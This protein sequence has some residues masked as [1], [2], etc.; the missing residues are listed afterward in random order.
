MEEN[1]TQPQGEVTEK[2]VETPSEGQGE[3]EGDGQQP[4][5][6]DLES[7]NKHFESKFQDEG[8]LREGLKRLGQYEEL[9]NQLLAKDA[10][11]EAAAKKASKYDEFLDYYK[12]EN[13]YGDDETFAFVEMKKK[14]PDRDPG[15]VSVIRSKDFDSMSDLDKLVIANKLTVKTDISDKERREGILT[16]LGVESENS[17]EWTGAEKFRL[18]TAYSQVSS[19]IDEIRNFKPEPQTFDIV[20]EKERRAEEKQKTQESL[21]KKVEPIAKSLVNNYQ[22]AKAYV[23]D[24][25]GKPVEIFNYKVDASFREQFA[26]P[27][28]DKVVEQGLDLTVPENAESVAQ[29]ID[30]QYKLQNF[31]RIVNEAMKFAKTNTED[32]AHNK[33]HSDKPQN[34]TEAPPPGKKD[35]YTIAEWIKLKAAKRSGK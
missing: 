19:A 22:E 2:P 28:I 10:E 14:F 15:L 5:S 20:A 32:E 24:K 27:L 12:P 26:Q 3:G 4:T 21:R 6:Y 16:N 9:N 1:T 29:Y 11:L 34:T 18:A 13:L 23:K 7:F 17:S 31:N 25:D 33:I 30:E 8:S 35:G